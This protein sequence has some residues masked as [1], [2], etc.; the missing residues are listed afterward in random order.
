ME[1]V[2]DS[3]QLPMWRTVVVLCFVKWV[4]T[5]TNGSTLGEDSTNNAADSGNYKCFRDFIS[6][7]LAYSLTCYSYEL[8]AYEIQVREATNVTTS[9]WRLKKNDYTLE[10]AHPF[11]HQTII[12][13][14]SQ[15]KNKTHILKVLL[16][17]LK[18]LHGL[19]K[20]DINI[21]N[22]SMPLCVT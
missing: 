15:L 1:L 20:K 14:W 6:T 13:S 18:K 21:F 4:N 10:I 5:G 8:V 19:V 16:A 9:C 11:Y 2:R 17:H 12:V 7:S 3:T 22:P